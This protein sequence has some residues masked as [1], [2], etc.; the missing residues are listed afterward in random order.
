MFEDP[1]LM[2]WQVASRAKGKR[3]APGSEDDPAAKRQT[4]ETNRPKTPDLKAMVEKFYLETYKSE[5]EIRHQDREQLLNFGTQAAQFVLEQLNIREKI[6]IV[7]HVEK[8]FNELKNL[9]KQTHQKAPSYAQAT[10]ASIPP[11]A[12]L[13]PIPTVVLSAS[14]KPGSAAR[15]TILSRKNK[16]IESEEEAKEVKNNFSQSSKWQTSGLIEL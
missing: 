13:K 16:K 12:N 6:Q 10:A 3:N 14:T 1:S 9:I 7:D 8:G 5:K 2:D 11:P 15:Y 4:N